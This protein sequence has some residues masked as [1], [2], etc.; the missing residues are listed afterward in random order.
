MINDIQL[1]DWTKMECK[2][3]DGLADVGNK[4]K[5]CVLFRKWVSI[6]SKKLQQH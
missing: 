2:L 5:F 3:G 6:S 4:I 1:K